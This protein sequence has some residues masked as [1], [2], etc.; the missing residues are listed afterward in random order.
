[1][2]KRLV[3]VA[4]VAV[5]LLAADAPVTVPKSEIDAENAR[6]T[7][8]GVTLPPG[9]IVLEHPYSPPYSS[10][11]FIVPSSW[12]ERYDSVMK[13]KHDYPVR[14]SA[15]REDLPVLHFLM[16]KTYAGYNPAK[17]RGWNWERWL[18][19]WDTSL[20]HQGDR[21]LTIAQA[22]KSW[23][24]YEQFQLDNHSGVASYQGF[25]SGSVSA[26]LA[27]P[28]AGACSELQMTSGRTYPLLAHDAGQ[29]PHAVQQWNGSSFSSASYVSYPKR[30]GTAAAIR[31]GASRIALRMA[32]PPLSLSQTPSYET[33]ADGI[34]Y[35]RMPSFTDANNDALRTALSKAPGLGKERAV[36]IDL[37]GNDG[38][39]APSDV[40]NNWAAESAIEQAGDIEQYGTQSCF[41][42]ALSF[43]LQQQLMASLKPPA[44]ANV[45]RFLQGVVDQLKA[46]QTCDVVPAVKQAQTLLRDHRFSVREE[47][48]T[49]PRLIA[50]V[51]NGCGSDCEYMAKVIAA[52][53]DSVIAGTSTFG[54]MGFT[55]PGYFVLP[56][57]GVAFRLALSRTDAY[58]D[59]RSVDGYGISVDV[60]LPT[61]ASQSRESIA[62]LAKALAP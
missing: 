22:F 3:M 21:T 38:G 17:L 50:V 33:I 10:R 58:G 62:A 35:V 24:A 8:L 49:Q 59:E 7:A 12:Y 45:S 23:G 52:L 44:N 6:W 31:C 40:L 30:D 60:L 19:E 28:A 61:Q 2:M 47:N 34:A 14:A 20:A 53:P 46:P 18:H 13:A 32:S 11:S 56:H 16:Q 9:G 29:Q 15:L 48:G 4:A 54:V 51:D 1:M 37:R 36:V 27:K 26:V 25:T 39:N 5:M 43:G 42:T 57:S 41:A 55:Q